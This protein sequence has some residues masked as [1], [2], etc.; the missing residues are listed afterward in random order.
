[1]W[2]EPHISAQMLKAHLN[3]D[4]E[5]ASRRHEFID[6]SVEWIISSLRLD[7]A[8]RVLDLG[9]GPGL[10]ACRIANAGSVHGIDV[11]RRSIAHARAAAAN[12]N[13]AASFVVSNYLTDELGGPYDLALFAYE[14]F[15]ALSPQQ[16]S[17]LLHKIGATLTPGGTLV[18]DVISQARFAT[19]R[20]G[21]TLE[22]N[23]M[24]GFWSPL[25][26]D[27]VH[28]TWT[29]PDICLIL[30][31]DTITTAD[32]TKQYWN[33]TQCLSP[34]DVAAE[35]QDSGFDSP[36]RFGDLAGAPYEPTSLTFAVVAHRH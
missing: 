31:R 23:L 7:P 28:E 15:C 18:M 25:P 8:A 16:R 21:L 3:P 29:Y 11:S 9:C 27:G 34:G 17:R 14:D 2:D 6:R 30:D 35:L 13:L 1:M 36:S 33:W 20:D 32:G 19:A 22:A 4:V 10:Y 12:E 26:Y 5:A 24:G